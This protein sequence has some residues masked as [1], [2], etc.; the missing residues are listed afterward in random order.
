MK[1]EMTPALNAVSKT[2]CRVAE[3]LRAMGEAQGRY[4]AFATVDP[5]VRNVWHA[6][7]DL[8]EEP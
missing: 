7:A 1:K 2:R 5:W 6:A 3:E 4:A 8:L